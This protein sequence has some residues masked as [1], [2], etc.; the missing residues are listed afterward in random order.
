MVIS[1]RVNRSKTSI[2]SNGNTLTH[3]NKFNYPGTTITADGKCTNDIE[4]RI[5]K[6]KIAFLIT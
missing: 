5:D 2:F 1:K 6:A 4:S 3:A